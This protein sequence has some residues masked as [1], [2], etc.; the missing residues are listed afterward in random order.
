MNFADEIEQAKKEE[1]EAFNVSAEGM[2]EGSRL[3]K[4]QVDIVFSHFYEEIIQ[5]DQFFIEKIQSLKILNIFDELIEYGN[6]VAKYEKVKV[7]KQLSTF[8]GSKT[9]TETGRKAIPPKAFISRDNQKGICNGAYL[10]VSKSQGDGWNITLSDFHNWQSY[11]NANINF[12]STNDEDFQEKMNQKICEIK[13]LKIDPPQWMSVSLTLDYE[14]PDYDIS[15]SGTFTQISVEVSKDFVNVS[16]I[17]TPLDN[18]TP[19]WI[20]HE[21][22]R[23]YTNYLSR[24]NRG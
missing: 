16:G 5:K 23:A 19:Q 11:Q 12:L 8:F 18:C 4:E 7:S 3:Y 15:S 21:V 20:K 22:A 24:K 2:K 9:I 13:S 6:L 1:E 10:I 14:P 17:S